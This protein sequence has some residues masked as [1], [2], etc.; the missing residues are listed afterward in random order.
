MQVI[1][2]LM[3][4]PTLLGEGLASSLTVEDF[5]SNLLRAVFTSINNLSKNGAR[6]IS[7][8]DVDNYLRDYPALGAAFKSGNGIQYLQDCDDVA[9]EGNFDYYCERVK[10]FSALRSLS[11]A[12]FDVSHIYSD[13]L[14][15]PRK[16]AE[17]KE[18][19]DELS[20]SDVF[21]SVSS[22]IAELEG[23]FVGYSSGYAGP[24][25][26]G[27]AELIESLKETPEIGYP[28]Q[29][30]IFNTVVRGA[31]KT[32]F[33]IRSGATSAGKSRLMFGDACYLA[34]PWRYSL[35]TNKWEH[36]GGEGQKVLIVTTE[37][38][39]EEVKTILVANLTGINEE[40]IIYGMYTPEEQERVVQ[41]V[42]IMKDYS[43]NLMLEQIPDPNVSRVRAVIKRHVHTNGCQYV[44]Y[45]YIFTSPSLL[46]EYR[47]IR[48][49]EDVVLGMLSTALKDLANE[50]GVFIMSATQLSGDYEN[51]KTQKTQTLLRG[52]KS[53]ADK[54]DVGCIISPVAREDLLMLDGIIKA[55]GG[56]QPTMVTDVYKVRRGRYKSARVWSEV[57][58]G[59]ARINDLFITDQYYQPI[60]FDVVRIFFDDNNF[61]TEEPGRVVEMAL[62]GE[63]EKVE[64]ATGEIVTKKGKFGEWL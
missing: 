7:V 38:D 37:L 57:D 39:L 43:G 14:S 32:K 54:V 51:V 64:V 59:T 9:Q 11:K 52:A 36:F 20:L 8:I 22:K 47:D 53:I 44:F 17:L 12:G 21:A 10:K 5:D 30:D 25:D 35:T 15:D 58:L 29:G 41:A 6:T 34:Y 55:R 16:E 13:E 63:V 45:D 26:E 49:R 62:D 56:K 23:K 28:L 2:S 60:P 42:K 3:R 1:G 18:K 46:N 4:N 19:F 40:K 24:A 50:L 48:I 27:I 31:R 33:Y 61:I